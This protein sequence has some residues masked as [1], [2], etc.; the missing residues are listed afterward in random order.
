MFER[1]PET[2][3][4]ISVNI[5]ITLIYFIQHIYFI[6][7]KHKHKLIIKSISFQT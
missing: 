3:S 2:F 4:K 6:S 7:I 1:F 5:F